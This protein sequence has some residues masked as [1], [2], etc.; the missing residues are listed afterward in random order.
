MDEYWWVA[1]LITLEDI[2]EEI[3]WEIRDETD[4]EVD[5]IREVWNDGLI[6]ESDVLFWEVL[7]KLELEYSDIGL[8]KQ[9]FSWETL[10][11]MITEK[12]K[13]FPNSWEK[14][15]FKI[16]N[17]ENNKCTKLEFKVLEVIN[18]KMGNIEVKKI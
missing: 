8:S 3:F 7:E 1:W 10:S 14:V 15:I 18:S 17:L 6:V 4:R 16:C 5:E 11:Y 13:R 9:E 2:V 12:L